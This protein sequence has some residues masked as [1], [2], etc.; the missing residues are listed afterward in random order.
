[1]LW[2]QAAADACN[3]LQG[4]R[5]SGLTSLLG[6]RY[7]GVCACNTSSRRPVRAQGILREMSRGFQEGVAVQKEGCGREVQRREE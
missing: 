1:M 3:A 7:G 4:L 2:L 5:R 6:R